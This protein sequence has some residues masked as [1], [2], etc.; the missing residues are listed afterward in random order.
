M[1]RSHGRA[2][3]GLPRRIPAR[4]WKLQPFSR[5]QGQHLHAQG[6]R[7]EALENRVHT[8]IEWLRRGPKARTTKSKARIDKAHSMIG[9]LAEM[10]NRTPH[11]DS[12]NRFF[13]IN[14]QTKQLIDLEAVSYAIAGRKLFKNV[15]FTCNPACAWDWLAQ[16]AAARPLCCVCCAATLFPQRPNSESRFAAHRLLRSESPA[17]SERNVAP[18]ARAR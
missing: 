3:S 4:Q 17:R 8:E 16:T 9:E 5:G 12:Q 6:K 1:S 13:G 10:N 15:N 11:R 18:R 7:Q 2:R 14:R